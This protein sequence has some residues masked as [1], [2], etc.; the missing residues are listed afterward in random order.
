MAGQGQKTEKPTPQ[1][2]KKAREEGRFPVSRELAGAVQFV[3]AIWLIAEY[4]P[5]W[6]ERAKAALAGTI[7]ETMRP[8]ALAAGLTVESLTGLWR[9]LA[10][11]G[12]MPLAA[13]GG[14]VM[15]AVLGVQ[16]AQTGFGVATGRLAPDFSRLNPG[17]RL[18][19]LAGQNMSTLVQSL[20]LLPVFL[21][22]TYMVMQEHILAFVSLPRFSLG[23]Q[24]SYAGD[25]LR[26]L[27]R[28]AALLF[29]VLGVVDMLRQRRKYTR[30]LS[31]TKQEVKEEVKNQEGDPH[32]RQRVRRLQRDLL[33]RWMMEQVDTASAVVVNPTHYAV[34]LKYDTGAMS[35]PRVV[36]KGKNYLAL[37]IRERAVKAGVPIVENPP[38]AQALY[39]AVDVGQEIPAHLYRAVAEILAYVYRLMRGRR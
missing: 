16:L 1:R 36:A 2:L 10:M 8:E 33:R 18:K 14:L 11:Q 5:A 12:L 7:R 19:G 38:L 34:A 37:R 28:K 27:L 32:V 30:D 17:P 25:A 20:I 9:A 31:M 22:V 23:A 15:A 24:V 35:A 26:D 29:V 4:M 13:A 3:A 21:Y 39:K 6:V